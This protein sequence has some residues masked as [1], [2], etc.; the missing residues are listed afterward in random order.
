M[1]VQE[2]VKTLEA[3]DYN[4]TDAQR[5]EINTKMQ[6][7]ARGGKLANCTEIQIP[8]A[9]APDEVK[10]SSPWVNGV[11][12]IDGVPQTT[13]TAY[14][15]PT[16]EVVQ[17]TDTDPELLQYTFTSTQAAEEYLSFIAQYSPTVARI[18]S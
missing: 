11:K 3:W 8:I 5:T 15:T 17:A 12:V 2:F 4:H 13:L 1:S 10:N 18:A 16:G 7:M 6:E 14:A 9:D